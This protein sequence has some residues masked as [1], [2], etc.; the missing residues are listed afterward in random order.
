MLPKRTARSLAIAGVLALLPAMGTS[1]YRAQSTV[2][3]S[4]EITDF[5]CPSNPALRCVMSGLDNPRG[6]AFGLE[7]AL[8]VAEA[9]RGGSGP[10]VVQGTPPLQYCYGPTGAVSRLWKGTQER[11]AVGLPSFAQVGNAT[12][13]DGTRAEGPND[14]SLL[15]VGEAYVVIGLESDPRAFRTAFSPFGDGFGRLVRLRSP[16]KGPTS[17]GW[18]FVADLAGFE[19]ENDPDHDVYSPLESNTTNSN[20]FGLLA[21]PGERIV[22]DAGG[23]DIVRVDATGAISVIAVMP[24]VPCIAG[25]SCFCSSTQPLVCSSA[26]S[27]SAVPTS[28]VVGPDGAW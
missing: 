14:I 3:A 15:G 4:F 13:P 20:P 19:I 21:L 1:M 22:A 27:G 11:I 17:D 28:I 6:L 12:V 23:N 25:A 10:C 2:G 5:P 26:R 8:Y 9:G 16:T 18:S 7:G 24:R